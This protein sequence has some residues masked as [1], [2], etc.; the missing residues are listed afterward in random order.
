MKHGR[1]FVSALT[2]VLTAVPMAGFSETI[3]QTVNNGFGDT[4]NSD[5]W[6]TPAGGPS[7]GNSYVTTAGLMDES[8]SRLGAL[9]S[10]RVRSDAAAD[11]IFAGDSIT[12]VA[13]TELLLKQSANELTEG[14]I[15][16]DGGIIRLSAGNSCLA[17]V[18]GTISVVSESYI[19]V[20]D[21]FMPEL[22]I[23]SSLSG[24]SVLHLA[25]GIDPGVIRFT[26][27]L[28][29]FTGTLALGG[30]EAAGTYDFDQNYDLPNVDV[31]VNPLRKEVVM[32]D[33]DLKFNSFSFDGTSLLA[34][35]AY[36]AN[37]L[38]DFFGDGI[39]FV[40]AGGTLSVY[41]TISSTTPE[42][43]S[44]LPAE[45]SRVFEADD[46][47]LTLGGVI[48]D[49][50]LSFIDPSSVRLTL[51]GAALALSA[52]D[53]VKV[54]G[55]TT[56]SRVVSTLET[57]DHTLALIYSATGAASG[58]FTNQWSFSSIGNDTT[59]VLLSGTSSAN[60]QALID[61][62]ESSFQDVYVSYGD[63]SDYPAHSAEIA[64]ADVFMVGR[65]LS[66]AAYANY[67]NSEA[68]NALTIPVV[69]FTSYI[70]RPDD[71]RWA[72]HEGGVVSTNLV[73][74]SETTVTAAGAL[75]FGVAADSQNDWFV[76][77]P[78]ELRA[79]G[80]GLVGDGEIL[81]SIGPDIVAAHWGTGDAIASTSIVAGERLLFNLSQDGST[82]ILP[83]GAGLDALTKALVA[84]T[85]FRSRVLYLRLRSR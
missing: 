8:D 49:A 73:D 71:S 68:F 54:A 15:I 44:G 25:A 40:D 14:N 42:L 16:L 84:Y 37:D 57:G 43:V 12:L 70:T 69:S 77:P 82:T 38:V 4:W 10:S 64:K 18:A 35:K 48:A 72:W 53:V 85:R 45:G 61:F 6:G 59:Y 22:T 80:S 74:G 76:S 46:F 41:T 62:L 21:F 3:Y 29:G 2:A 52:G 27:N 83:A 7:A 1:I 31:T 28:S 26:G 78:A 55:T 51:D 24:D 23:S 33:Q 30:G 63:Y 20:S 79:A 13:G 47:P 17:T 65:A 39:E 19:G 9:F 58:P 81:A 50:D 75:I 60:D 34:G 11:T 56:V 67:D 32:L 36:S 5:L 66:S